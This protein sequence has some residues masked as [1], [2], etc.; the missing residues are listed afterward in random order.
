MSIVSNYTFNKSDAGGMHGGISIA[1]L[2]PVLTTA[3]F[4]GGGGGSSI[5]HL[6]VPIGLVMTGGAAVDA[7]DLGRED[8]VDG[9]D[10]VGGKAIGILP[11]GLFDKMLNRVSVKPPST[12]GTKRVSQS[13]P[14]SRKTRRS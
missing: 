13:K 10:L 14:S 7:E 12:G 6:S 11:D 9:K 1:K 5:N 4:M 8:V 2:A 3:S